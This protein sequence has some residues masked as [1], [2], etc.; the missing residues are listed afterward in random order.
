VPFLVLLIVL[1]I[2]PWGLFGSREQLDRV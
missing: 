1:A 2:R